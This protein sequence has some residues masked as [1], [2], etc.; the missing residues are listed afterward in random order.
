MPG[1]F[2]RLWVGKGGSR[3]LSED[4]V[5]GVTG[6]GYV[7]TPHRVEGVADGF[8]CNRNWQ[9]HCIFGGL[10]S[11]RQAPGIGERRQDSARLER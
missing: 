9:F 10:E 3:D 7:Q 2:R 5:T 6:A 4:A 8:L 11:R 1:A